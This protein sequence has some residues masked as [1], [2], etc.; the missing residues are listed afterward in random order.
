MKSVLLLFVVL[1]A[2]CD[3]TLKPEG[4]MGRQPLIYPDYIGV[5]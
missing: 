1:I 2:G 5:T 4:E 3:R